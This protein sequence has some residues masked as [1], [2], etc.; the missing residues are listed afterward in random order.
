MTPDGRPW[1]ARL[2]AGLLRPRHVEPA[3]LAV[4]TTMFRALGV[5]RV[6][7]LAYA[8]YWNLTERWVRYQDGH[9]TLAL[10]GLALLAGWTG[11]TLW[12]YDHPARRTPALLVADLT[13]AVVGMLVTPYLQDA[14]RVTA[15]LPT[16]WVFAV[17]ITWAVRFHAVGGL[18][19]AAATTWADLMV[20]TEPGTGVGSALHG[21]T[22]QNLMLLWIGGGTIG[23]LT[24]LLQQ[25]AGERDL[26][27]RRAATVEER[28]RLGRAI[29]DGTLQVLAMV[30]RRGHDLG[31]EFAE[32]A[33]LAGKQEASLR[34]LI[35]RDDAAVVPA[36]GAPGGSDLVSR[37][38]TRQSPTVAV[39]GPAAP[40]ML[41][42]PMVDEL[43]AAVDECLAN[44]RRH[45]GED[46]PAWVLVEDLGDSVVVSVRDEGPG[47]DDRRLAAAR[48]EGRL[49][50]A[51]CICGRLE[52]LGGR[53]TLTTA[54]EQGVEWE[55]SVPRG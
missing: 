26:A 51:E 5:L 48:T 33:E 38:S 52:T 32:L 1:S 18:F 54:P 29:H 37:L 35:Q 43:A 50:V 30:Q 10:V 11:F 20:K 55:L 47:M 8:V 27:E 2:H 22:L 16:F 14:D 7:L 15:T 17:V 31:G 6:V 45:V 40:V 28:A 36:T 41:P 34:A 49:G 46:A 19:A 4:E 13:V 39:S 3:A 21:V 25:M 24:G 9:P 53:A 42:E 44:V 12:A 23:Y